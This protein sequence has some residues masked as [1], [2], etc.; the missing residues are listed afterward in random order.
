[1]STTGIS[2]LAA[3]VHGGNAAASL[4]K[5]GACVLGSV[6]LFLVAT[7][8][9][10]CVSG[11]VDPEPTVAPRRPQL[12]TGFGPIEPMTEG[13]AVRLQIPLSGQFKCVRRARLGTTDDGGWTVCLDPLHAKIRADNSVTAS[14]SV[15]AAAASTSAS[16]H[17]SC[18]VYSFGVGEE[19]SFDIAAEA[20]GCSVFMFDPTVGRPRQD[21]SEHMHF[22]PIGL[23]DRDSVNR[24]LGWTYRSFESIV[25][26]LGHRDNRELDILKIGM[27]CVD[28]VVLFLFRFLISLALRLD[29]FL[30][31]QTLKETSGRFSRA[32]SIQFG[33]PRGVC[34]SL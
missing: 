33:L 7:S 13:L 9:G 10:L 11:L 19:V 17:S 26:M 1:M 12:A 22:F 6:F 3:T 27:A 21:L 23:A 4:V 16:R 24:D 5:Y 29:L 18:L 28:P 30:M 15:A 2:A 25:Q 8:I 20:L 31:W 34:G 14:S 32:C